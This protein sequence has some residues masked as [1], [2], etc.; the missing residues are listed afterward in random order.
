MSDT[1]VK[2]KLSPV[3]GIKTA[4]N[5]LRGD[6]AQELVDG[7]DHVGKESIQLLKHH[8]TYQ[9][10]NR[11]DRGGDG[12]S[13]SFMVR[14]AIP[15]GKLTSDQ[16]LAE[17]DLCDEVGNSTL[18]IT[19][20]QGLQLHGI[21]K[22]NLQ[23]TIHRINEVQLTT[24]AACGDVSRNV[25]CSPAP[26]KGDPV[27]DQMHALAH[28][29]VL[30]VRPRTRAYHELWLIDEATRERQLVGGGKQVGDEVE[31]LY[32][33]TYMPRK[34][35]FGIAL[36]SDNIVD[37][38]AQDVGFMA[39]AENWN[40]TGYNV[41]V[42][43]SFGVTPSA[44][45]TFVA[46]AQPMCYIPASQAVEVAMA[47]MKVQRDFGNRSDRKVARMKYLIHN[48]GLE[49][50]KQK[51]EEYFGAPLAP[52]KP[53]VVTELN[54]GLGWHAQGDGKW[55]YGL[56]VEN[57]RIKDEGDYRLKTA[58]REVCRTLAPP[59][60]LTP[61]QSIIFCDLKESD[62]A[63]LVEI[64]RR[65]GVPLSEDITAVRRW[66]MAC[67]ALPTCGLAVTESERVLPSMIDQLEMELESLG[68]GG[69]V[70]TTRMT[71][72]PNGCARPYNSDIGL[73]GK[74]KEKYTIFLGG[75]RQGDR[76]N[77]I[78]KDLVPTDQVVPTLVPV[79]RYF[80]DAR[81]PGETLGDFCYR[82]GKDDLLA[83]CEGTFASNGEHAK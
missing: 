21:L 78:Y 28:Q 5:Y 20:R 26:F 63:R 79:L 10:D 23:Q 4:S 57:G 40:V 50:F 30:N 49:R 31:P 33:P 69:E 19:T 56:N 47:I 18:R 3:E 46:I 65:N 27:Y 62:R 51:V 7:A 48:W 29:L 70:F 13:Y 60:R 14:S 16:L 75:R 17:L 32:G 81:S 66:S 52:P 45:K 74:T 24:L 77:F 64:F 15:G 39:I 82:K 54:D 83:H 73:V 35:K 25:M 76:L 41:L 71:G 38:Y 1:Q 59:L 37:L 8:G 2:E 44:E 43:G 61:H 11:D 68:L 36:P 80:R 67:P 12:K 42:G 58:L 22:D 34:F 6:I 9:Q 55:F 72:C 53:V